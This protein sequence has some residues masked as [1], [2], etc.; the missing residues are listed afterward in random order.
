MR[1]LSEL[2]P[3][4]AMAVAKT[5]TQGSEMSKTTERPSVAATDGRGT[6][7][8]TTH[9]GP[10]QVVLGA[11]TRALDAASRAAE[12]RDRLTELARSNLV[13]AGDAGLVPELNEVY[14]RLAELVG[15]ATLAALR[16]GMRADDDRR[17]LY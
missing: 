7:L 10:Q 17:L 3:A 4:A 2:I 15:L 8:T 1:R 14:G 13:V 16:A 6:T 12:L 5:L 9:A 11:P